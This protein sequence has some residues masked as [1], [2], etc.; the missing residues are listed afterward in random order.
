MKSP[1]LLLL[2]SPFFLACSA[3]NFET[4][5]PS[6][7][8]IPVSVA[9]D[10]SLALDVTTLPTMKTIPSGATIAVQNLPSGFTYDAAAKTVKGIPSVGTLANLIV[11]VTKSDGTTESFGPYSLVPKGDPLRE[12][13]WHLK[14]EGQKNFAVNGGTPGEDINLVQSIAG[15]L[16]GAGITV[17]VSD[18]GIE[19]AHEDLAA[20]I[21]AGLSRNYSLTPP[22][23]GDPTPH[24]TTD[25]A[26]A[27]GTAVAGLI[28]AVG[29]NDLGG[30]G[31][32]PGAKLAGLRYIG[33]TQT[34][35]KKIDQAQ[36][37]FDI[38]NYSYGMPSIVP[39]DLDTLYETQ[40]H[41]GATVLRGGK[42]VLYVKSAGNEFEDNFSYDA[43]AGTEPECYNVGTGINGICRYYGNS[44]LGNFENT[45]PDVIVVGALTAKGKR[46]SYSTPGSN[47]WISAPGGEFGTTDPAVMT[48]DLQGC[49][50][51]LSSTLMPIQNAFE[52]HQTLNKFCNYT[53]I[54]NGTSSAAPIVSG[55]LALILEANP[56]LTARDV[57]YILASTATKV[58]A[59][60]A[61]TAH[62]LASLGLSGHVYQ[63]GWVRNAAGFWFHNWYGFGR[64]NVDAAV[65]AARAYVG[66]LNPLRTTASSAGAAY[67]TS[68]A[69]ALAIPD[70]SA[71]G[72]TSTL[73]VRH[74]LVVE[75]IRVQF[76]TSH[77]QLNQLGVELT[78]PA[79]TKSILLNINSGIVRDPGNTYDATLSSNAFFGESSA[80]N[81]TLKVIDG[82]SGTTGTLQQWQIIVRGHNDPAAT[83]IIAPA[84]ITG[85][86]MAATS[87]STTTAPTASY[88][89]SIDTDILRYEYAIGTTSGA[90]NT[91]EWTPIGTALTV[92]P[93][94]LSL[95]SGTTYY[96]SVRAVDTSENVSTV[97]TTSWG[98]L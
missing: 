19:T 53:S 56:A 8:Q 9:Q 1:L 32:A 26:V 25:Y 36:G 45:S 12:H 76:N 90:S 72:V 44:N 71:G 2:T 98:V 18:S 92:T 41:Y 82:K 78:S 80:G 66:T 83:D 34:T 95:G 11:I 30:R 57:K 38:F 42:G 61:A 97:V 17:A 81:W 10:K 13:Q 77:A 52:R 23:T 74:N 93:T 5:A 54:M 3:G 86:S 6:Y 49:A 58:D 50:S 55:A 51:G 15:G 48:T 39:P 59:A 94:G 73:N 84:A 16:T 85:L 14:N 62:P 37:A 65:T 87:A 21:A 69:L 47:L 31:V 67:Y 24:S 79:G 28:A 70:A 40:L 22:Y 46:T 91:R 75:N 7:T 64:V 29:W 60:A 68:G 96:L 89:A 4:T 43:S 35:A 33:P 63:Q 88:T 27:H 20:N